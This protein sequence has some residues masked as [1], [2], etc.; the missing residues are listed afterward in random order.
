MRLDPTGTT[1]THDRTA[2]RI[3][4]D[5]RAQNHSASEGCIIENRNVRNQIANSGDNCLIVINGGTDDDAN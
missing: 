4:G 3:H 5:N 1:N 2:F